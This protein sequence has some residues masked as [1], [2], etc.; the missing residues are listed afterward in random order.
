LEWQENVTKKLSAINR[1][2][3]VALGGFE[4]WLGIFSVS[5]GI[6]FAGLYYFSKVEAI[7]AV[8]IGGMFG[9]LGLLLLLL[10][11]GWMEGDG[12]QISVRSFFRKN[13]FVWNDLREIYFNSNQGVMALVGANSRLILPKVSSW[14]G[15]D[16]ELLY[17]LISYKIEMSKIEP[18]ESHKPVYWLSKNA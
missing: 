4:K 13:T 5:L 10:C 1:P 14:S 17:E 3:K 9:G 6:L 7:V 2:L 16:R 15:K 18:V 8:I 11:I 12:N